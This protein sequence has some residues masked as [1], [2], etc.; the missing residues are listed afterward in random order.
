[1]GIF[2]KIKDFGSRIIKPIIKP[3]NPAK[4]PILRKLP[5]MAHVVIGGKNGR[6][7]PPLT[8]EEK[9]KKAEWH[10]NNP[11]KL[12]TAADAKSIGLH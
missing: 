12:M 6:A 2:D 3:F 10:K 11:G 4:L 8:P 5:D 9:A 7:P 1:M